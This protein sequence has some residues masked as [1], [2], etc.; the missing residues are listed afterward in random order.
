MRHERLQVLI[1][2]DVSL[3]MGDDFRS[4]VL[5]EVDADCLEVRV[6]D[7]WSDNASATG[8]III[9]LDE[10]KRFYHEW[11]DCLKCMHSKIDAEMSEDDWRE[12]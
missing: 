2:H 12:G 11:K 7:S 1:G 9:K 5:I 10:V 4:G 3:D 6:K 8:E